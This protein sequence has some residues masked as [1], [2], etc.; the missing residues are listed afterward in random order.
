VSVICPT[1]LANNAHI[2]RTQLERIE[3]FAKRIQIDLTDG[4][5]APTNTINPVQAYWPAGVD[6]D[7]HLMYKK[8]SQQLEQLI[9]MGPNMIIL[10]AEAEGELL[11]MFNDIG[12]AGIEA[13]VALLKETRVEDAKQLI[14]V[15]DHVLIFSGDLGKFGGKVDESLFTK[16]RQVK[17]INPSAEIGW[18]G[19]VNVD[20]ALE[21]VRAGVDVL[22]VGG[23]IQKSDNPQAAYAIL[24]R[25][26]HQ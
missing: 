3:E 14:E 10:H 11:E 1:I 21:L 24:E 17:E 12:A 6:V 7:I 9:H 2:Y 13:G 19:G 20:N 5:F 4:E 8:P 26:I 23:F 16:I 22:N 25:K 15:A 18:D